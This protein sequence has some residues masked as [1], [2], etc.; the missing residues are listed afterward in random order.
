MNVGVLQVELLDST[1]HHD[2]QAVA[3][4][5][6]LV[7]RI[8]GVTELVARGADD[9]TADQVAVGQAVHILVLELITGGDAVEA[10]LGV[11]AEL[12]LIGALPSMLLTWLVTGS[13]LPT[14]PGR[15]GRRAGC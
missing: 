15:H 7:L 1:A 9:R 12:E 13:K 2:L 11:D 3:E 5:M 8:E 10:E 14:P 6:H 4:E